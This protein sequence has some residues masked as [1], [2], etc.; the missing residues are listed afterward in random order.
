MTTQLRASAQRDQADAA[1]T[2][3]QARALMRTDQGN[4][5]NRCVSCGAEAPAYPEEGQGLPCGH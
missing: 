4:Q 2:N 5:P 1:D 3:D